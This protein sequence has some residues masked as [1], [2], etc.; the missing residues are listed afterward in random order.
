MTWRGWIILAVAG[1]LSV[2][3]TLFAGHYRYLAEQADKV[4]VLEKEISD[5]DAQAK[6]DATRVTDLTK[7]L[8]DAETKRAAA[9]GAMLTVSAAIHN[10]A[11]ATA[12]ELARAIPDNPSCDYP[13]DV[14][15]LL[16]NQLRGVRP[17]DRR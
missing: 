16:D 5:R 6:K 15:R 3:A 2:G 9:E 1:V 10:T 7:K 17:A 8:G 11:A 13:A 14:G 12:E 4:P